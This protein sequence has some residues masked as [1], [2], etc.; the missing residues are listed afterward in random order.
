MKELIKNLDDYQL[1]ELYGLWINELKERKMI[2][3]NN[4]IGELGEYLAIK[5]YSETS[6]LPTLQAA[7]IGTQNIDAISRQG[8]RYSIKSTTRG[9]TGV[10][11]GLNSPE[12]SASEVQKFEYV[13]IVIFNSNL[14]LKAIYEMDWIT[15]L[16]HKRWHKR[17]AAWNLSVTKEL[18]NDCKIIYQDMSQ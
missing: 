8:D 2:R 15:F 3:T 10:F 6:H 4:I 1:V 14:S 9:T 5:Y 7:P 16:H 13:I 17:M 18:I 11:Y 12:S